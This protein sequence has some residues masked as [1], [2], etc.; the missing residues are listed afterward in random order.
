[1]LKLKDNHWKG[2]LIFTLPFLLI[3]LYLILL[4]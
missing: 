1:M 2:G 3:I 4:A